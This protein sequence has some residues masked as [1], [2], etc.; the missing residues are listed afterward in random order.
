MVVGH[1]KLAPTTIGCPGNSKLSQHADIDMFDNCKDITTDD[2]L[3][4]VGMT[5][6]FMFPSSPP[7]PSTPGMDMA[8]TIYPANC[9]CDM[10]AGPTIHLRYFGWHRPV[11]GSLHGHENRSLP[12]YLILAPQLA[13]ALRHH[14]IP[15]SCDVIGADRASALV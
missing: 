4:A 9:V 15:D 11:N 13:F 10:Q 2:D 1:A 8:C 5:T 6:S 14:C 7:L 3:D 12:N